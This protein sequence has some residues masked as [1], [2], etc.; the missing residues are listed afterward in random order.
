MKNKR[1]LEMEMLGWWI[2]GAI[3]LIVVIIS[4]FTL[5]AKG[6]GALDFINSLFRLR[7]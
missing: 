2:I 5:K 6:I 3:V 7:R 1:G 4:Y